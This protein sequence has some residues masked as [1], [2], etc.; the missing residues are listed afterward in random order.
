MVCVSNANLQTQAWR[1]VPPTQEADKIRIKADDLVA[2]WHHWSKH[3]PQHPAA[4]EAMSNDG[5][6]RIPLGV[7][8][9]DAKYTL[10]GNKFVV[11]MVSS[12]LYKVKRHKTAT[13][14]I[15]LYIPLKLFS[16][17]NVK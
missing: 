12:V 17:S 8:G 13:L 3:M 9:D 2:F 7:S 5:I 14:Q 1:Y 6:K 15:L 10:A 11:I 16:G 4:S